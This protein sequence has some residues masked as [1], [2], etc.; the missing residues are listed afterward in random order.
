MKPLG[1]RL[2]PHREAASRRRGAAL[3]TALLEAAW[4]ELRAV[5]YRNFTMDGVAARAGTA[6]T[7]LYRRWHSRAELVMAAMRRRFGSVSEHVPDTGSLRGDVL[8]LFRRLRDQL[9]E[10]GPDVLHGVMLELEDLPSSFF[11]IL[12]NAMMAILNRAAARGE[13]RVE[14]VTPRVVALPGDLLRYELMLRRTDI[15]DAALE[16][17]IDDIFLPLV[18]PA[19]DAPR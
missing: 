13:A 10:V 14:G 7:V 17:I 3:E 11:Q 9:R 6:K 12:P 16:E 18:R 4:E 2:P 15:P 8:S 19:R 1:S 5:G